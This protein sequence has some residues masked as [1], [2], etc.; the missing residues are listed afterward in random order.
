M[1]LLRALEGLPKELWL[2]M[3]ALASVLPYDPSEFDADPAHYAAALLFPL[4]ARA[5]RVHLAVLQRA[6]ALPGPRARRV[7]PRG[8]WVRRLNVKPGLL[9][10]ALHLFTWLDRPR[11]YVNVGDPPARRRGLKSGRAARCALRTRFESASCPLPRERL[12][13]LELHF[14]HP[15]K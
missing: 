1:L 5:R 3:L 7:L 12:E 4:F 11:P 2:H 13:V 9:V 10:Y 14:V 8:K 15:D 6:G